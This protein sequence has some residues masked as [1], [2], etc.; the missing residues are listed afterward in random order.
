MIHWECAQQSAM[1]T[2][3][4]AR[5][6]LVTIS[7][8]VLGEMVGVDPISCPPL[9]SA[10]HGPVRPV[11]KLVGASPCS[12]PSGTFPCEELELQGLFCKSS[13]TRCNSDRTQLWLAKTPRTFA[14]SLPRERGRAPFLY[15]AGP[16]GLKS[17]Q[18]YSQVSPFLL[19][20]EQKQL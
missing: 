15:V 13:A 14:Q 6:N 20:P 3:V 12:T 16:S 17:A 8:I 7:E 19:I 9:D 4:V 11:C 2:V 18:Y 1:F 5:T 10:G